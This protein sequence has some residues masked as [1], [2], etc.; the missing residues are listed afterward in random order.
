MANREGGRELHTHLHRLTLCIKS[1]ETKLASW[2]LS[3]APELAPFSCWHCVDWMPRNPKH[4]LQDKQ[5]TDIATIQSQ[6]R[7]SG[8]VKVETYHTKPG[9]WEVLSPCVHVGLALQWSL[10]SPPF[11]LRAKPPQAAIRDHF[12]PD[13]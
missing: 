9:S 12:P 4:R 5:G 11:I 6:R 2:G 13:C 3:P 8:T 1:L 10:I 7:Q